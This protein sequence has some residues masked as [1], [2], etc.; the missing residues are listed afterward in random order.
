MEYHPNLTAVRFFRREIWPQLRERWPRLV[1]RL[2][3][4]NPA[5]SAAIHRRRSANRSGWTRGQTPYVNSPA[6]GLR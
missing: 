2:V 6:P 1:W 3:G 5:R 4:K